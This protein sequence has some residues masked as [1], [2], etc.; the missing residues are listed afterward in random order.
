[1][2]RGFTLIELLVVISIISLLIAL[3]LPALGS[4]R[5]SA[6][7]IQGLANQQQQGRAHHVYAVDN[8]GQLLIGSNLGRHQS[9]YNLASETN[10]KLTAN[11]LMIDELGIVDPQAY[12][13]P[14]QTDP[15]FTYDSAEN[16][17][18]QAGTRTRSSFGIRP[19]NHKYETISWRDDPGGRTYKPVDSN[20][21]RIKLLPAVDDYQSDDGLLADVFSN[22]GWIERHHETGFNAI[23]VDGSGR[24]VSIRLVEN[25]LDAMVPGGF[26]VA[27]N[28]QHQDIWEF[29]IK[30]DE[31]TP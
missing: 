20:G 16:P 29:A 21:D 28:P 9:N 2:R 14:R 25:A 18:R 19:F 4:A 7:N 30:R 31:P 22:K 8:D 27:N 23:R 11:G 13:C 17:W 1:M 3:L 5:R 26:T 6:Q 12:Y 10:N 15:R 24:F